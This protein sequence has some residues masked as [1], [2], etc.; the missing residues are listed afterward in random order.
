[1]KKFN[2]MTITGPIKHM[3]MKIG[4]HK[5][6]IMLV[7]GL[8][9]GGACVF[10]ACKA[11]TKLNAVLD[12]AKFEIDAVKAAREEGEV[13]I[14]DP[15]T[16]EI[17]VDEYT[18]DDYKKDITIVYARNALSVAKLYAPAAVLG[19]ASVGLILGSHNI[20]NKRNAALT[21]AYSVVD[22]GFKEYRGRVVDRF[23]EELDRELKYNVRSE[24]IEETVVNEKGKEKTVKKTVQVAD[25]NYYSSYARWFNK[26]CKGWDPSPEHSLTF[27]KSQEVYA[28]QKLRSQKYLFLNDVYESLG[29]PKTEAGQMIGW[30]YDPKNPDLQGF[31]SFGIYD[32]YNE[33]KQ[34]F[35]NGY[36]TDILLDF[37]VD[38]NV[39]HYM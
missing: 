23:G 8:V 15:E 13:E 6:T 27:L 14:R 5:P 25:P 9:A 3:G 1:M 36:E 31:V 30:A 19:V 26:D 32:A 4:K 11:S 35:V 7:G 17:V 37:N 2:M 21:A 22:K 18:E 33:H 24:E 38:G 16:N 29:I 34:D 10:T 28:N 12:N 20:I 39:L